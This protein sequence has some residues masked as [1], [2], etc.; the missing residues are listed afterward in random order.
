MATT[1][2]NSAITLEDVRQAL[3]DTDP[4]STNVSALRAILGRG[5][6]TTIQKHLDAI[7]LERA[8]SAGPAPG[9]APAAPQEAVA[10]MWGAAYAAAQVLTLGRLES[11]TEEREQLTATVAQ[12]RQDLAA[13]LVQV[14][15]SIEAGSALST[16]TDAALTEAQSAAATASADAAESKQ[17]LER[18]RTDFER[19]RA[20]AEATEAILKKDAQNAVL[21]LQSTIDRLTDQVGELKSLL[22]RQAQA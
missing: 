21:T 11:V 15:A 13:A 7:R 9:Q 8:P 17:L 6:F 4:A 5:S 3:A 10:A 16:A 12:L 2:V 20:E 22:H 1:S 18:T 14:D 19:F